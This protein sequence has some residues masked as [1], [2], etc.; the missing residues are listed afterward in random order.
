MP[1]TYLIGWSAMDRYYYG[2]R[3]AANSGPD[4]LWTTYFTS[5]KHVKKFRELHGEPDIV[6]IK[7]LFNT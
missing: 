6:L 4:D 5:S 1:F 2:A 3:W 7:K